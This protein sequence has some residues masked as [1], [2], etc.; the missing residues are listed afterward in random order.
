[1][2][3]IKRTPTYLLLTMLVVGGFSPARVYGQAAATGAILGTVTDASGAAIPNAQVEITNTATQEKRKFTTDGAGRYD[4]EGL[5]A[6]GTI[7]TVAIT[8]RGFKSFQSEGVKLDAG[9]RITINAQLQVGDTSS[10]ITVEASALAVQTESGVTGGVVSST[11]ISQLQ[12]NGRNFLTLQILVP[13]VNPTDSA[14]EQGGGG[15]T[16][17]NHVSVNGMGEEFN[18]VMVDGIYNMNTGDESQLNFNPPLDSIAEF[19]VLTGSYSA[20]YGL[21]GAGIS[22]V[23]SKSGTNQFHG[24]AYEFFRNDA[25]DARPFFAT[26][27]SPLK[28][29]IFGFSFGGP[30]WIPGRD[31]SKSKT[32]FFGN[33]EWR[34]RNSGYVFRTALP[35]AAIL[36]GNFSADPTLAGG[37]LHLDQSSQQL[38]AQAHPGV[39][40][41]LNSTQVNPACFDAN[42]LAMIKKF[43]PSP[44]V[45]SGFLNYDTTPVDVLTQRDDLWRVDHQFNEKYSLMVRYSREVVQ[46]NSPTASPDIGWT[47]PGGDPGIGDNIL[48]TSFNNMV[49]F[50]MNLTPKIINSM[51]LGQTSDKPRLHPVGASPPDG[52]TINAPYPGADPYKR[53][54]LIELSGGWASIGTNGEPVNASDGE[55]TYSDDFTAVVGRHVLQAGVLYINGVKRQDADDDVMGVYSFSGAH[56]G[57]PMADFLLGLDSSYSQ[58]DTQR[59]AYLH[60]WQ[61]EEYF[62]DDWKVTPRFTLNLGLRNLYFSPDTFEGNGLTDFDPADFNRSLAPAVQPNGQF[63]FNA[64]GQPLTA[65]GTVANPL[66]GLVFRAQGGVSDGVYRT[67]TFNLQPRFGFA[68]SLSGDGKTVI[69][70][71][72][73]IGYNRIPLNAVL[74]TVS[75]PPFVTTSTYLNGTVTNPTAGSLSVITPSSLAI[76]GPPGALFKPARIETVNA[77]FEREVMPN[78]ILSVGTVATLGRNLHEGQDL[79]APVPVSAPSLS[80]SNPRYA[81]CLS[82]GEG[83][84]AG[85]FQF[86][87]CLNQGVVSPN[88]TRL[89]YPG[90]GAINAAGN[91]G[92][93]GDYWGTSNYYALQAAYRYENHGL[94]LTMAYTRS[95]V[96]TD[97]GGRSAGSFNNDSSSFQ[98]PR[99]AHADYGPPAWDR[100]NILNFSYVYFL[101]FLK[102]RRDLVGKVLGGWTLSGLTTIESGLALTAGITGDV[103]LATR[104]N[105]SGGLSNPGTLSEWF[106]IATYSAPAYGFFGNC[107]TGTI[108]G[109][110][111]NTWNGALY[112]NFQITEK[113]KTQIR[114]EFFNFANHP[115]FLNV[116]TTLGAGNFGQVTSALQP[117]IIELGARF[118]F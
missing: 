35:T 93:A 13:G 19:R 36:A 113:V 86:D 33:E 89:T 96:L 51:T 106:N 66:T 11:Q 76:V 88:Y 23:E 98:N 9:T 73:S 12:L 63:I 44:N 105:C 54:P 45:G 71:G 53:T 97:V 110:S 48:T 90:W 31:K 26:S 37:A 5:Q 24:S 4:E 55:L 18:Q 61:V 56:S 65:A 75:N 29:N 100:P 41:I 28:Q 27:I 39:N 58:S 38:L 109:P 115:S 68:Y 117:R 85:G 10:Q 40:C 2:L 20:R 83:I 87:P 69:R 92:G 46:D 64:A 80:P 30:I 95:K 60:Y 50:N 79:N 47:Q 59:R 82:P 72:G 81:S 43:W 3:T 94:T 78:G 70:G 74:G 21:T 116:S 91:G 7:Y 102:N 103:G 108:R 118:D 67:P 34:R 111:Q 22:L 1:M 16:T 52:L 32:F 15:L 101:P 49:R 77:T 104:P 57:S 114:G 25:M 84:P 99:D 17:F 107:G 14:Q 112:K 6:S 8:Q 42:S 62:Q